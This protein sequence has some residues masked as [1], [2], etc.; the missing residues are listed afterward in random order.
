[1]FSL[2]YEQD[3]FISARFVPS[4]VVLGLSCFI[5]SF[6][7]SRLVSS[8]PV[9]QFVTCYLFYSFVTLHCPNRLDSSS[10]GSNNHAPLSSKHRIP[11][12]YYFH[13]MGKPPGH[14]CLF[15]VDVLLVM[16]TPLSSPRRPTANRTRGAPAR[17]RRSRRRAG[18]RCSRH[19]ARLSPETTS[20][21]A[22]PSSRSSTRWGL[23]RRT[24]ISTQ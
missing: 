8:R 11:P 14:A 24:S 15:S 6:V 4:C 7:S 12:H 21:A 16:H 3:H 22:S 19:R 13:S 2:V 1:M 18:R 10:T 20:P 23:P 17:R 5:L 9:P